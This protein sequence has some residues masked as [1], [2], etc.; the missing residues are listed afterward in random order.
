MGFATMGD[1]WVDN[2]G[3]RW[4]QPVGVVDDSGVDWGEDV[5]LSEGAG[6]DVGADDYRQNC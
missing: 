1:R 6:V 4:P 2:I 5:D 3:N